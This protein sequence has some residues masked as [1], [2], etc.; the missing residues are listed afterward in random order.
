MQKHRFFIAIPVSAPAPLHGVIETLEAVG[1]PVKPV[2]ARSLH[3]TLRFLG[4]MPADRLAELAGAMEQAVD[5]AGISSFE[6]AFEGLG[7]FPEN[8]RRPMRV[9]YAH[10]ANAEPLYDLA[11]ALDESLFALEPAIPP[12]ERAFHAHLT[13]ARVKEQ[14]RRRRRRGEPAGA[15]EAELEALL[16]KHH[17]RSLGTASVAKVQL[18]SSRLTPA[19]P[20]HTVQHEV[21]L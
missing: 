10:I 4:D 14:P 12:D 2:D 1:P 20:I 16:E 21:S 6:L 11:R 17:E 8:V 15:A 13:L 19:G 7:R 18:L 3:M 9:L 5:A